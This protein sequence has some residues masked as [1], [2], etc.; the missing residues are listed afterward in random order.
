MRPSLFIYY[1]FYLGFRILGFWL[2][3]GRSR[4]SVGLLLPPDGRGRPGAWPG[5]SDE[6]VRPGD[7]PLPEGGPLRMGA[8]PVPSDGDERPAEFSLSEDGPLRTGA[9][10]VPPGG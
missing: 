8:L 4:R 6:D 7:F 10:P 5:R 1:V 3:W 9:R 2:P